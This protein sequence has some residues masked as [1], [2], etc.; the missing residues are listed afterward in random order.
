MSDPLAKDRPQLVAIR[1]EGNQVDACFA[2]SILA[3]AEEIA[4][5]GTTPTIPAA[6]DGVMRK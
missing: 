2:R 6:S 1:D 5:K 4:T 3:L